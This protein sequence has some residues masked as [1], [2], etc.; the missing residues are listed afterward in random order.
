MRRISFRRIALEL[1]QYI[2]LSQGSFTKCSYME[3]AAVS[4]S[5]KLAFYL[6]LLSLDSILV[7][8]ES[9]LTVT[10]E[11]IRGIP[12]PRV[13]VPRPVT[14][15]LY[16]ESLCPASK[17]FI[18]NGLAKAVR[19]PDVQRVIDLRLV[20][21]G[22]ALLD[23]SKGTILCQV[24]SSLDAIACPR[25]F[26]HLQTTSRA[27]A[28]ILVRSVSSVSRVPYSSQQPNSLSMHHSTERGNVTSTR[29]M[30]APSPPGRTRYELISP[31]HNDLS[32]NQIYK[33]ERICRD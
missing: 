9:H 31:L 19:T 18:T 22:N 32:L 13:I 16:Y 11:T 28:S 4:M 8:V 27:E 20:P 2:H 23:R 6:V 1:R 21:W 26:L 12:A 25:N 7:H 10:P 17:D 29:Y 15:T 33:E 5:G 3:M 30:P 24:R 14:L